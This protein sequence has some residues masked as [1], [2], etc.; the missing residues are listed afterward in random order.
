MSYL[1]PEHQDRLVLISMLQKP[2]A[3]LHV[4][5]V[6]GALPSF[7]EGAEHKSVYQM[8][9]VGGSCSTLHNF[10]F[11]FH[12]SGEPWKEA[13]A[14]LIWLLRDKSP[15]NLRTDDVRRCA[16]K[17]LNYLQFC[18]SIEVDW[19]DFSGAR[20]AHRPTYKYFYHLISCGARSAAVINQYTSVIYN[21][22][23][24]VSMQWHPIDMARVDTV[25]KI[26]LIAQTARGASIIDREKRSQTRRTPPVS[27][28]PLGFV[29][30]E[31]EDLRPLSNQEVV[32]LLNH[33]D[34]EEECSIVSRLIILTSLLTGARKQSVLTFRMR[35]LESFSEARLEGDGTY[36]VHAGP[37]TGIDTKFDKP[38]ILYFPKQLAEELLVL[39]NSELMRM[40]RDKFLAQ[41]RKSYPDF[42]MA[43]KDVYL[44][45]SNQGNCYYMASGDP[46]YVVVKSPPTG[47]V[48]ETITKKLRKQLS[49]RFP[50]D[51]SY[52]WLRATYAYQLYQRLQLHVGEGTLKP[53]EDIGFIQRRMHHTSRET[54]ESYLKLFHMTQ[55]KVVAQEVW[56][57]SLFANCCAVQKKGA[58]YE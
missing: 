41:F 7:L 34:S 24:F 3:S 49:H 26:R 12:R 17:L 48:T 52:H 32:P 50:R 45:L 55:D 25:K 37:G 6:A 28:V 53:G 15:L 9:E 51:F 22:Y 56:E 21:F 13:N 43:A 40:R 10:P 16:S 30:E 8:D 31:G 58:S 23:K 35:H 47:Q 33:L 27:Q 2:F 57:K 36:R 1:N 44:F 11:L 4:R 14:Y 18:E 39:A 29:R 38:Q 20:P 54:T 19:L 46:R 42:T 5:E